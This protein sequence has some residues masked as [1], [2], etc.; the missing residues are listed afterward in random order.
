MAKMVNCMEEVVIVSNGKGDIGK[1]VA[2][3]EGGKLDSSVIPTEVSG[4]FV[5]VTATYAAISTTYTS[6]SDKDLVIVL[7]DENYSN[8][9]SIYVYSASLSAW[10]CSGTLG[11]T[12]GTGTDGADGATWYSGSGTPSSEMGNDGDYYLDTNAY[13]VYKKTSGT[14]AVIC[15]IKGADGETGATGS[16]G[17]Q[18]EKGDTGSNGASG[19]LANDWAADTVYLVNQLSVY[20]GVLY[21]CIVAHTSG[22]AFDS[23]Y[24]ERV[25]GSFVPVRQTVLAGPVDSNGYA[26][27]LSAVSDALAI[28]ELSGT[29]TTWANGFDAFGAVDYIERLAANVESAWSELTASN[30]LYLYKERN[31]TTGAVTYGFSTLEPIYQGYAPSSSSAEQY[32]FD[33]GNMV[34]YY[35]DGSAWVA[36]QRVFVGEC[37]T[38]TSSVTSVICYAYSGRFKSIGTAITLSA[39]SDFSTSHNIGVNPIF[40]K[41]A[42]RCITSENGYAVGDEVTDI[43]SQ[44]SGGEVMAL[45]TFSNYKTIGVHT[46]SANPWVI[47]SRSTGG[48]IAC[49]VAN[50]KL[51]FYA[52]RGW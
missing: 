21:R 49:T 28:T 44:I 32:W 23:S 5:G 33:T 41:V 45:N 34:G 50:W 39:N 16:T 37:V 15:N 38:G 9:S 18:G 20:N 24:F 52:N 46:A 47:F 13:D 14:W 6:P 4:N 51:V 25:S 2:L 29:V 31:A 36:C 40:T 22:T 19:N 26:A 43:N 3:G 10:E 7:A 27:N 17:A 8:V 1:L 42:L 11:A 12:G 48:N 30:T 35:Y